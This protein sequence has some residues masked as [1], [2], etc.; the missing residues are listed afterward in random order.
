MED[1][2][3]VVVGLIIERRSCAYGANCTLSSV[4]LP[5]FAGTPSR[6]IHSLVFA[7][8]QTVRVQ[9]FP[10]IVVLKVKLLGVEEAGVPFGETEPTVF[11]TWPLPLRALVWRYL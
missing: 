5:S 9:V 11:T 6:G 3:A 1:Y 4:Q 10:V 7:V 8:E 2:C